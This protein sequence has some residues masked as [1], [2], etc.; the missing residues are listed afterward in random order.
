MKGQD[1]KHK[2]KFI[3]TKEMI[4]EPH[5]KPSSSKS[6]KEEVPVD[7]LLIEKPESIGVLSNDVESNTVYPEDEIVLSV[8]QPQDV[9]D[10]QAQ[11]Q[12]RRLDAAALQAF[13]DKCVASAESAFGIDYSSNPENSYVNCDNGLEVDANDNPTGQTCADAC[14]GLCCAGDF[15]CDGFNGKGEQRFIHSCTILICSFVCS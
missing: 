6:E 2:N 7:T 5:N 15:A 12:G 9:E 13:K 4:R 14:G 10:R 1:D 8:S 3:L 11:S